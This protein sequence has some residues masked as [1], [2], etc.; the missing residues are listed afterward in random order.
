MADKTLL[1]I[2]EL[3][4]YP[5]F[6]NLYKSLGYDVLL[7]SS[8]RK[9]ISLLKKKNIDVIVAAQRL[10]DLKFIVLYEKEF[11]NHLDKLRQQ[12]DFD[13]EIAFPINEEKMRH[14]LSSI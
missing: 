5:D 14:A 8:M 10:E 1:A 3:G 12:Y 2:I 6:R 11:E 7:E 9:A 4:G 13:A